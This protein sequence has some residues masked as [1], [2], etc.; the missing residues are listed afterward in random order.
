MQVIMDMG[1]WGGRPQRENG[2]GDPAILID[3]NTGTIWVAAL[4]IHGYP[5][6]HAWFSSR[7]GMEP[8]Q[9]GQFMVVKSEDDG[10]TWSEPINITD[11]IKQPERHLLTVGRGNWSKTRVGGIVVVTHR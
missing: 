2:I 5:D 9:T 10:R 3:R 1:E 6:T 4:W 8:A 11:Q 7:Q